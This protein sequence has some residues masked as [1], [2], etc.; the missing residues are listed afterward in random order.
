M[1]I[2]IQSIEKNFGRFPALKGVSLDIRDG[3]LIALLGPSGSGK[4]TLLRIIAG[5][6]FPLAGQVMFDDEDVTFAS[7]ADRRVGFVFQQYALFR[8]MTIARNVGFGLDVRKGPLRPSKQ[9]IDKKVTELLNLVELEGLGSRYPAQLS[10]GQRQRVALARA[11]AVGP[12]VLLLDEPFGALDATVRKTLRRELRRIH[13]ATGV[14]TIFVTHD[15]DEALDLAD[16]VAI[17]NHGKIE[18]VGTP[19]EVYESPVSSFVCGFVG[20]SNRLKGTVE[21][22]TFIGG[23]LTL[24]AAGIPSGQAVAYLRPHDLM[25]ADS[26]L[27]ARIRRVSM[28]GPLAHIEADSE[29]GQKF[30]V[31]TL[32]SNGVRLSHGSLVHLDIVKARIF[33]AAA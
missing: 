31:T 12:R 7:A 9:S 20:E 17:L 28:Q 30:E 10:G 22:G 1:S 24:D 23:G 5:L 4:T 2:T 14:T 18:Q 16:R 3:E 8:H 29:C 26:G 33:A 13:D 25:L 19:E 27:A 11:L 32:R 21:A 15:Q 6:E